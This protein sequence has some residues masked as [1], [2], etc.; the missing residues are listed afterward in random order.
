MR[1]SPEEYGEQEL[2]LIYIA[3][4][5]QEAK[6]I[7]GLLDHHDI[8]YAVQVEQYRAGII[9]VGL[10]AGA[11]FYVLPDV[12]TRSRELLRSFGYRP[13]EAPNPPPGG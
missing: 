11:F 13:Q 2:E 4:R 8:D 7:E 9:F 10:R 6:D 12:A 3:R 1:R 5:L